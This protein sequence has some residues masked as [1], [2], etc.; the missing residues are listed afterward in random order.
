MDYKCM[1]RM[2]I[3]A[4]GLSKGVTPIDMPIA[5]INGGYPLR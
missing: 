1:V 3:D 5:A 2:H 4:H